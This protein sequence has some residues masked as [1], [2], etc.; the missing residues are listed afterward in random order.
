[1][2]CSTTLKWPQS[3]WFCQ[4]DPV[5]QNILLKKCVEWI[6]IKTNL[7][8]EKSKKNHGVCFEISVLCSYIKFENDCEI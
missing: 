8:L 4:N 1:M 2:Y 3:L 5:N 6:K 7:T